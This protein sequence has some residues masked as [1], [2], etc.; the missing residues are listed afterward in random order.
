MSILGGVPLPWTTKATNEQKFNPE[1][2][3]GVRG[4]AGKKLSK[5]E[6]EALKSKLVKPIISKKE[7]ASAAAAA[8]PAPKKFFGLF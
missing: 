6:L 2:K 1:G 4:V 8:G 5:E 7:S 3:Q